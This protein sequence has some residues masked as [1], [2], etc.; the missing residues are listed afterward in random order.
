MKPNKWVMH[1]SMALATVSALIILLLSGCTSIPTASSI[2]P[3]NISDQAGTNGKY[4][5]MEIFY[6]TD[7]TRLKNNAAWPEY[8]DVSNLNMQSLEYGRL[9]V[10]IP[11][12]HHKGTIETK[13]WYVL[14]M[15]TQKPTKYIELLSGKT[16][17]NDQLMQALT[18]PGNTDKSVLLFVHGYNNS[19]DDAAARTA[20]IA[21]DVDFPGR[22]MFFSWPSKNKL[23]PYVTD[24]NTAQWAAADLEQVLV[25]L[26]KRAGV[27]HIT[28]IAHSMGNYLLSMALERVLRSDPTFFSKVSHLVMA[29]PDIDVNVFRKDFASIIA[30]LPSVTL[31]VSSSDAAL[32]NSEIINGGYRLG[33]F[34]AG[35]LVFPPIETVDA[36]AV[37]T[38]FIG[39][40]Y[41][42]DSPNVLDDVAAIISANLPASKRNHMVSESNHDQAQY[43]KLQRWTNP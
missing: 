33:D 24:Q 20:Q 9:Q 18:A 4:T 6:A 3:W 8:A 1:M 15:G 25:D 30:R 23:L 10:S 34:R 12:N 36:S 19:F 22:V 35:P 28:I 17:S 40:A 32:N 7:R 38:D 26:D 27:Q 21:Y 16:L 29:A 37:D 31:Y 13:P 5:V 14:R 42:S 43:W 39:H 2:P 41:I 11:P